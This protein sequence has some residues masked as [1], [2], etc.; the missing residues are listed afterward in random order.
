MKLLVVD[1][2]PHVREMMRLTLEAAGYEIDEAESGEAALG[3]FGDGRSYD[4]VLLDQKMPGLDGLETMK[5][6]LAV[7][8]DKP[9]IMVTAFASIELAVEAMRQG[10]ANFLRKPMTPETLRGSVAAAVTNVPVRPR[11][12]GVAAAPTGVASIQTVTLNGFRIDYSPQKSS[13]TLNEH[14]FDVTRFPDGASQTVTITIDP[15]A[16]ARVARLTRRDL[17]ASGAFWR[18]QAERLLSGYLWTEGRFPEGARLTLR[19]VTRDD[20]DVAAAWTAD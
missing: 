10:A 2:E 13:A 9:I 8:P 14:V 7:D 16:V 12:R 4:A 3:S 18:S 15:E 1:D 5:R 19:D 11:A 17:P 6:L 20:V